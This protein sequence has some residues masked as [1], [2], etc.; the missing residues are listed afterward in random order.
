[1]LDYVLKKVLG[2]KNERELKKIRPL[3]GR[4]NELEPEYQALS[5]AE[6]RE[7]IDAV[8]A[9]IHEAAEPEEPS[10]DELH[11]PELERRRELL[12]ER[13]KRENARIQAALDDALP[14]V[15]AAGREAMQRTLGMRHYDVQLMGGIVLHQGRIAEMKT[16]EGKTFVPTPPESAAP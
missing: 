12:K 16:G 4:V 13:R 14:E 5:D 7:R 10:D 8:R 3:V 2:T 9:D 1:M 11:H 6:I 15:F